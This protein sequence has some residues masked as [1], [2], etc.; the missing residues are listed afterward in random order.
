[1]GI[2]TSVGLAFM[3][4]QLGAGQKL[5]LSGTVFIS[6]ADGA[7]DDVLPAARILSEV[8]FRIMDLAE[9]LLTR[10]VRC[11]MRGTASARMLSKI[12]A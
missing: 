4:S 5:P 10:L 3:K 6:V 8:G 7:K 1:M 2:D 12:P 11:V 9:A